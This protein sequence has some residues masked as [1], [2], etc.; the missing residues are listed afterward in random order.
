MAK[1]LGIFLNNTDSEMKIEINFNN[2]NKLKNNFNSIYILDINNNFS[3]KLKE[4][5]DS[6]SNI[7]KYE[8]NNTIISENVESIDIIR[9]L[10]VLDNISNIKY[11]YITF[12]NDNY[13]YLTSLTE[14]FKYVSKH[15]LDFYSYSDTSEYEYHYEL[16]LITISS[17]KISA[18]INYYRKSDISEE[19]ESNEEEINDN[20]ES[21]FKNKMVYLKL[22][23]LSVNLNINIFYNNDRLYEIL[24]EKNF[25]P[26]INLNK[27]RVLKDNYSFEIFKT[28]PDSFDLETYRSHDDLKDFSDEFLKDHFINYGQFEM[29]I[30][31]KK[32]DCNTF[33]LPN[34]I[35]K[36]LL[37]N[38]LL[39]F[40]D[41][42]YDFSIKKYKEL[43]PD[44]SDFSYERLVIH[45]LNFGI[46]EK[47]PYL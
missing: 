22:A 6:E 24:L 46:Y 21:V 5:L 16:Y 25:L 34:F 44:L 8:I 19:E 12:I 36:K 20:V 7:V 15:K 1:H 42:P 47:R 31:S 35:R 38:N 11:D 23:Y 26:I 18:F 37:E 13:I 45:Y 4:K 9:A 28:I 3:S 29:R 30:Y 43:N 33:I 40:F 10:Y 2:F 39:H 32:N 17:S 41:I 14:Y 27:L